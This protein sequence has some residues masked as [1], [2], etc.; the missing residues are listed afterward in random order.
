MRLLSSHLCW[1]A[2]FLAALCK[3]QRAAQVARGNRI[4]VALVDGGRA[5]WQGGIRG[6]ASSGSSAHLGTQV[7]GGGP[8][9]LPNPGTLTAPHGPERGP[10]HSDRRP[11]HEIE[12]CGASLPTWTPCAAGEVENMNPTLAGAH[13][14]ERGARY[15]S[16]H[17][18]LR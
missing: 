7:G 17:C 15:C 12:K 14:A 10:A 5:E 16:V 2:A 9:T 8:K 13:K 18:L 11:G 1:L 6:R 4:G 3:L